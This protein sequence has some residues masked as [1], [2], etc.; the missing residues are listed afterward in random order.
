LRSAWCCL[1]GVAGLTSFGQAAFVG[2]GAY[3]SAWRRRPPRLR[4]GSQGG[5]FAV[6]GLALG[7]VLTL[8][9][10]WMLGAL[11]LRLSGHYL[12]L[13]TIA[14]GI[15]LYFLFGNLQFLGGHTGITSIPPLEAFGVQL[16]DSRS[17]YYLIW[18]V[19]LA[20]I[21]ITSN[22]LDSREGRAIRA[23]KGGAVMAESMGIDT[24]RAK[25]VAFLIA[26]LFAALSGGCTRTC[27]AS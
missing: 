8:A 27:S 13:G 20:A 17:Y 14:W 18:S 6:A 25:I 10:A 26:A 1:T 19:V 2:I 21:W 4:G 9:V 15:S 11:T 7:V 3:A 5:R 22:L 23:L 24:A 16:R 12:P